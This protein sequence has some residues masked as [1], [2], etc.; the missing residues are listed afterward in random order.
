MRPQVT[1][2]P[3][4]IGP[5]GAPEG[6]MSVF[7]DVAQPFN[8]SNYQYWIIFNTSGNK[9]TPDTQPMNS[10]WAYSEGIEVAG[11]G[12]SAFARAVQFVKNPFNPHIPPAFLTIQTTPQQLQLNA[13]SNGSG[14]EFNVIFQRSVFLGPLSSPAPSGNSVAL[15]CVHDAGQRAKQSP[16]CRLDGRRRT[17]SAAV[18]FA[19]AFK[20]STNRSAREYCQRRDR[21]Q[22]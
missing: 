16:V 5:G 20:R 2:N 8:F 22:S 14:T 18:R 7:F 17:E 1:P 21:Q 15:Q 9:L 6:Y 11:N 3:I 13:N 12:G 19:G 10:N 4:G